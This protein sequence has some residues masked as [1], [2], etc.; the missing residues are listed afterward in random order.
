MPSSLANRS[1]SL[2]LCS[3]REA[4]SCSQP[5]RRAPGSN[6]SSGRDL[7]RS[8]LA[9]LDSNPTHHPETGL[10]KQL[11]AN[12][13]WSAPPLPTHESDAQP[14]LGDVRISWGRNL[15]NMPNVLPLG[16]DP[17]SG[18]PTHPTPKAMTQ[19]LSRWR[20][21]DAVIVNLGELGRAG[22]IHN[23]E[24]AVHTR[25][26]AMQQ[27]QPCALEVLD[28]R[29]LVQQGLVFCRHCLEVSCH[30][31]GVA[32]RCPEH[33]NPVARWA[34]VN[35]PHSG[36]RVDNLSSPL[37]TIAHRRRDA[38]TNPHLCLAHVDS[39]ARVPPGEVETLRTCHRGMGKGVR[40]AT[41]NGQHPPDLGVCPREN[42]NGIIASPCSPPSPWEVV[43]ISPRSFS[44]K[45]SE[46]CPQAEKKSGQNTHPNF[47]GCAD[48]DAHSDSTRC[49]HFVSARS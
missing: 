10:Q 18:D 35:P 12:K 43:W 16:T 4:A 32:Q 29:D 45:N 28:A 19:C 33:L 36:I 17:R 2:N 14:L 6:S 42:N 20:S 21:G 5:P 24:L 37:Q 41:N 23:C 38:C 13:V 11:H 1:S 3:V 46:R 25:R 15:P 34:D 49:T 7:G 47:L 26:S 8:P 22:V 27:Q 48:R 30:K 39:D 44:H 31:I 40:Q 9:R